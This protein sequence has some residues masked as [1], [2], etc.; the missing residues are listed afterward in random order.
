MERLNKK[1]LSFPAMSFTRA[2]AAL[3][4]V[5]AL[6]ACGKGGGGGGTNAN[7]G[8]NCL[9]QS[10]GSINQ[11]V[12][13][14]TFTSQAADS[15]IV[16]QNMQMVAQSGLISNTSTG[17][18]Y[19]WYSGPIAVQ[20]Q[21][22]VSRAIYDYQPY[23]QTLASN[24]TIAAGTYS[25]QTRTVG[26]MGSQGQVGGYS[27][28]QNILVP[29]LITTNGSIVMRIEAPS[30]MGLI[31]GGSRLWGVVRIV[32]VNGVTCSNNFYGEFN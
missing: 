32:S 28:G 27:D 30:P 18:P 25:L 26:Y 17:S 16:L 23:S 4:M 21:M 19:K 31:S 29:D 24:C 2:F 5:L 13:L 7:V 20:G 1:T 9:Q 22:V 8:W 11:P 3:G 12:V 10:C 15:S 6:A 14:T